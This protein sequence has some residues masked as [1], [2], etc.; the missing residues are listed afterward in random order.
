MTLPA[1]DTLAVLDSIAKP[2]PARAMLSRN[3]IIACR[4][5]EESR[6]DA[7]DSRA[8]HVGEAA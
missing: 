4:L 6:H 2:S 7:D 1:R 8:R 3:T 5:N